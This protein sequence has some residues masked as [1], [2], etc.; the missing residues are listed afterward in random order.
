MKLAFLHQPRFAWRLYDWANSAFATTILAALLPIYFVALV[1]L[2]GGQLPIPG[3]ERAIPAEALWGYAVSFSM[4]FCALTAPW[5]GALADS[6]R[7]R[8]RFL[9]LFG[10]LGATA[11]ALLAC[12][13]AGQYRLA[14]LLFILANIGFALGNIFYDAF[15]PALAEQEDDL[16]RL[17]AQGYAWGYIGGGLALL[18][19][20]LLVQ[21][22]ELFGFADRGSATRAAFL[23]TGLWWGIFALPAFFALKET[24]FTAPA[25]P[26]LRGWRDYLALFSALRR[27]PDLLLFLLAFLLYND[28]IQTIITVAAIFGRKELG[29]SQTTILQ[30]FL[31]IQFIA[32]PGSLLFGRIAARFG[33]KPTIMAGLLAFVAITG[34]AYTIHDSREFWL[35]G[36]GV[37]LI[38]GGC[39]A[40]SRSLYASLI[41]AGK[42]AEFFAFF[43]VSGK[44]ASLF[45]PLL[46]ALVADLTGSSR[47]SILAL[48]AFFLVG[49]VLLAGVNVSRGQ[50]LARQESP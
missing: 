10:T 28:G 27:Y 16:D 25:G 13:G 26:P 31:M 22:P 36:A 32:W 5:L 21:W 24:L 35:L 3:M 14:A 8:R 50:A 19:A 15:L 7:W 40:I 20:F 42:S 48:S 43:T 23:L 47:L 49:L 33:A 9:I 4:A 34:Y 37:A 41:P 39:Q 44:F 12:A 46:F 29:L 6:R 17:S 18:L 11:T 45:G 1:P 30:V 2:E 38:F